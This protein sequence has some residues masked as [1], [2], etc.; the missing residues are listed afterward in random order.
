[1]KNPWT[2]AIKIFPVCFTLFNNKRIDLNAKNRI[3]SVFEEIIKKDKFHR[4]I[5]LPIKHDRTEITSEILEN[6]TYQQKK[7]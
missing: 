1:M 4:T 6:L 7:N 5:T 3:D 2:T